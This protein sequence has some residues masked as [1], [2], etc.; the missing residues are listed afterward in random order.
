MFRDRFGEIFGILFGENWWVL[1][2][3]GGRWLEVFHRENAKGAKVGYWM[4]GWV[5]YRCFCLW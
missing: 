1:V 5:S 3:R 2:R 4:A